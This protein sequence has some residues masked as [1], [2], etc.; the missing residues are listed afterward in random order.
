MKETLLFALRLVTALGAGLIAGVFFAF[1]TFV[2]TAL[3]RRPP[4]E[5]MAAMQAINVAVLNPMFLGVFAGTAVASLLVIISSL[6]RWQEPGAVYALLG[7]ALY[8]AGTFLV[9]MVFN[10]P[11]ND[12]LAKLPP[13]DP[14]S[15][16]EWA[17]YVSTWTIWNHVRTAAALAAAALLTLAR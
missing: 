14:A 8:I 9:T 4:D 16:S 5:G 7:G 3:A 15:A 2:M 13:A 17:R 1:S 10:V 12:A 6:F 11:L